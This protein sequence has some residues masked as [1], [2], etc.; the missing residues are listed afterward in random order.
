MHI[1]YKQYMIMK[2]MIVYISIVCSTLPF[3]GFGGS[4]GLQKAPMDETESSKEVHRLKQPRFPG[5]FHSLTQAVKGACFKELNWQQT[6]QT[7]LKIVQKCPK[8]VFCYCCIP[9]G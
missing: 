4:S 9:L 8:H 1:E 3:R 5:N 2:H 7:A 6:Q